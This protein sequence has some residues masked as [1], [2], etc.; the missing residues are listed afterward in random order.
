MPSIDAHRLATKGNQEVIDFLLPQIAV[1]S[2]WITIAAFYK[3]LHTVEILFQ[4]GKPS[5]RPN[6]CQ[7][8]E[9]R[10]T[11]L[12][13]NNR[14]LHIYKN[15]DALKK[16]SSVARYLEVHGHM[17][18]SFGDYMTPQVVEATILK[19]YLIQ[20]ENSVANLLGKSPF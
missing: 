3:A 15:Y 6:G 12:L 7:G 11:A 16:A 4:S 1:H 19:H 13:S 18:E 14:Y 9:D 2:Q 20:V 8:H 17:Y 5:P 10:R